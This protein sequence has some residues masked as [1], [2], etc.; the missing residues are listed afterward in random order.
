MTYLT[1]GLTRLHSRSAR[2]VN[3]QLKLCSGHEQSF[4][5]CCASVHDERFQRALWLHMDAVAEDRNQSAIATT[6]PCHAN[7]AWPEN[8]SRYRTVL[9]LASDSLFGEAFK[10]VCSTLIPAK[11][12]PP[13]L[14]GASSRHLQRHA[15]LWQ[16]PETLLKLIGIR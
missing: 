3:A 1:H 6:Y 14:D 5:C 11:R 12:F 9:M 4:S 16:S 10:R 13:R 15:S 8:L 2:T 7:L